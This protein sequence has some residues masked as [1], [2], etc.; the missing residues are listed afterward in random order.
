MPR[1]RNI[2]TGAKGE[3]SVSD[4]K[5]AQADVLLH[6]VYDRALICKSLISVL[7]QSSQMHF[8]L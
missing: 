1:Q 8:I 6:T 3:K 4:Q 7:I 5:P 2:R